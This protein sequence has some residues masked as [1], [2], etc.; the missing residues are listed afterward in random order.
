MATF[1]RIGGLA[2]ELPVGMLHPR[3]L[4]IADFGRCNYRDGQVQAGRSASA[5]TV[6]PSSGLKQSPEQ[7]QRT[8]FRLSQ[9]ALEEAPHS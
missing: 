4:E 6:S 3:R 7:M 1:L 8:F 9:A 5:I 2:Q